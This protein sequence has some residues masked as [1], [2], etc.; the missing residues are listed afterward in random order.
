MQ[1]FLDSVNDFLTKNSPLL[2]VLAFVM[3]VIT[4]LIVFDFTKGYSDFYGIPSE[5]VNLSTIWVLKAIFISLG[6]VLAYLAIIVFLS[7][8]YSTNKKW[9]VRYITV[10]LF[11]M[12]CFAVFWSVGINS[13]YVNC[14]QITILYFSKLILK[15][16]SISCILYYSIV[17][18]LRIKVGLHCKAQNNQASKGIAPIVILLLIILIPLLSS[19]FY[20]CGNLSANIPANHTLIESEQDTLLVIARDRNDNIIASPCEIIEFYASKDSLL[21]CGLN[22]NKIED[23]INRCSKLP[24]DND[25][26][27]IVTVRIAPNLKSKIYSL[28]DIDSIF[29]KK[30]ML[31]R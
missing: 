15:L 19:I 21:S 7:W 10:P 25:Y 9:W 11:L 2:K 3:P 31:I 23:Y 6:I 18:S 28:S 29:F 12:L 30:G 17:F 20:N 16:S 4:S 26:F 27:N 13:L 1:N 24:F 22:K 14:W 8:R 5:I